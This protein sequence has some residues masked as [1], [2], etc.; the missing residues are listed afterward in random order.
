MRHGGIEPP[1]TWL[2]VKCSTDWASGTWYLLSYNYSQSLEHR[3]S[4][5]Y[6]GTCTLHFQCNQICTPYRF[7]SASLRSHNVCGFAASQP[8]A[9]Q[10]LGPIWASWIRTNE[11]RSQSPVPYRLAIA[12]GNWMHPVNPN[13]H[14]F[15]KIKRV[16][17]G[18]WTLGLQ[19]HN[20][21][22]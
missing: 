3:H 4:V 5:T 11:C 13:A 1:T 14:L 22:R 2:K 20:L 12:Q 9:S 16:G 21:A 19:S 18:T 8:F 10:S 17:R 6:P 7:C 15:I